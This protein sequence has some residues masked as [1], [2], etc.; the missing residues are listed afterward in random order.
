M[1]DGRDATTLVQC[2]DLRCLRQGNRIIVGMTTA[3]LLR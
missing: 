2:R 1:D 3:L